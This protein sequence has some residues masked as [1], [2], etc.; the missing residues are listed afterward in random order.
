MGF[1]S[2]YELGLLSKGDEARLEV[3][4]RHITIFF[5]HILH[6]DHLCESMPPPVLLEMLSHYF[7]C[8]AM[9]VTNSGGTLLDF[10][11]D[12]VLAIWNAPKDVE[13]H[14]Y[15]GVESSLRMVESV[16]STE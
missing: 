6:F 8:V 4:K 1:T 14:A 7:D 9:A 13:K 11:G 3:Y 15:W 16:A 2:I 12:M 10:I 5:S